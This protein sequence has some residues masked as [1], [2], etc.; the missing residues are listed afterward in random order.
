MLKRYTLLALFQVGAM[1]K[2]IV[3]N[4]LGNGCWELILDEDKLTMAI[5]MPFLSIG[6][7]AVETYSA[8]LPG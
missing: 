4:R 2:T 1:K 8:W 7:A 5:F 6:M 3:F